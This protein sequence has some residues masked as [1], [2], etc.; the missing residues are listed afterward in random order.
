ML[1]TIETIRSSKDAYRENLKR[2]SVKEERLAQHSKG[3]ST[4]AVDNPL[5]KC[6][7]V[8]VLPKITMPL[9]KEVQV[10]LNG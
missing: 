9:G 8:K 7:E 5:K 2:E 4:N 6:A 10:L 1:N 3:L